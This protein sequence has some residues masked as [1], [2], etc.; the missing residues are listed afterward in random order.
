MSEKRRDAK[1]RILRDGEVQ[2]SDGMYMYRYNDAKGD[3]RC[4]YSWRLVKTDKLP[5]GKRAAEPLREME[6]K[7]QQDLKDGIDGYKA[8][9]T[10][11]NRFYDEYISMKYELKDSTRCNYK[12]MWR[13]FIQDAIGYVEI[14]AI[15]YSDVKKFYISLIRDK[16]FKPNSV[17]NIQ[18]LLHPVFGAAVRDGYIRTNPTD[19][20]LS[21][22]K[23][24]HNWEKPK[25][26]A[27][28]EKQQQRFMSFT[29]SSRVYNH[30]KSLFTILLGT[31]GRIGEILGLRWQDCDFE[32][33]LISINH[34]LIYR[35][36]ED[37]KMAFQV[38]TPK[39]KS[40]TRI[41]PMFSEVK[42]E[43]MSVPRDSNGC[44]VDGYEGFIFCNR[45]GQMLNPHV[46]NRAIDRIV[47]DANREDG[48][49]EVLPHFSVHNLR[50]T[51]CTRMC[52]NEPNVKIIQEIMGHRNISTTMDV[53]NEATK[54]KKIE[55]FARLE[56]RMSISGY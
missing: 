27:L 52:E 17:E 10:T 1:G 8:G 53:Y 13:K 18:T 31:G 14:G 45:F 2:R 24:S 6:A 44:S 29:S 35:Q 22:I 3:R 42:T 9:N 28:T 46:V 43:L 36:M 40:G 34:N 50:H 19:G 21:E 11:L 30:W 41:V 48:D 56:G 15:K 33:G 7:V 51:F 5:D 47:R 16:G 4:L 37:G 38:T 54:D 23:K 25:R 12:Y 20:V 55:S 26:H 32:H 49:N 39:T